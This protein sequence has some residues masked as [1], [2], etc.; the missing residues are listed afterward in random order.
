VGEQEQQLDDETAARLKMATQLLGLVYALASLLWLMWMLV[1]EHRKR[2]L[3]MQAAA[4][5]R[6][7]TGTLAFRTGHRA[8]GLELASSVENYALPY[9]LSQ[10]RDWLSVLYDK[11]RYIA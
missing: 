7:V 2:L 1:P 3:A 8:M 6:Q 9:R 10:A 5:M 4:R 11:L